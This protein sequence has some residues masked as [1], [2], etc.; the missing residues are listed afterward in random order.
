[1]LFSTALPADQSKYG[2]AECKKSQNDGWNGKSKN[3]ETI[4]Q[5]EQDQ[6]PGGNR[7]GHSHFY[8][9]IKPFVGLCEPAT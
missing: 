6:T 9:P 3:L 7:A 2:N 4:Q 5:K 1:M 8:S